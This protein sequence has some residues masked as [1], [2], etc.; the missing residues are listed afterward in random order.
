MVPEAG[1]RRGKN[2]REIAL[3]VHGGFKKTMDVLNNEKIH[4][5][6]QHSCLDITF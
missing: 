3:A 1:R 6:F 5:A 2:V 4:E